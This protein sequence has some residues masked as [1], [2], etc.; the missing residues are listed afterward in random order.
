MCAQ[1]QAQALSVQFGDAGGSLPGWPLPQGRQCFLGSG[2]RPHPEAPSPCP[3][4]C[5]SLDLRRRNRPRRSGLFT[6]RASPS[7]SLAASAVGPCRGGALA[8]DQAP[9]LH[10]VKH[11][12]VPCPSVWSLSDIKRSCGRG[13]VSRGGSARSALGL[14]TAAQ[15]ASCDQ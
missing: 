1:G 13:F 12:L 11:R 15:Q 10:R 5:P 9:F 7:G 3:C 2:G 14:A 8:G 6:R 4:L